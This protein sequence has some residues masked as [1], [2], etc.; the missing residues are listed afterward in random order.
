MPD[1]IKEKYID[2]VCNSI[3]LAKAI[4]AE[5]GNDVAKYVLPEGVTTSMILTSNLREL[6]HM[7]ALRTSPKALPEFQ[8]LMKDIVAVMPLIPAQLVLYRPD[9][10]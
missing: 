10:E 3:E 9:E 1:N 4:K 5:Y 7:Y 8:E 6:R 2:Y